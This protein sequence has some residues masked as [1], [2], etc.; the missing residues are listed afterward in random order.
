MKIALTGFLTQAKQLFLNAMTHQKI[1]TS[2]YPAPADVVH[3]GVLQVDDLRL[4]RIAELINPKKTTF[5]TVECFDT[6]GLI[7]DNPSHNAKL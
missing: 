2:L 4:R 7:K 1:E 5:A 6:A 3:K